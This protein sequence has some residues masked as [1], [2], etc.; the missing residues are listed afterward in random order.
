[1]HFP[2]LTILVLP[3]V[4]SSVLATPTPV[5]HDNENGHALVARCQ[6]LYENCADPIAALPCDPE[7][8]EACDMMREQVNE[9]NAMMAGDDPGTQSGDT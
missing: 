9:E 7:I 1:M 5:R 8:P 3:L 2:T 4:L 6:P